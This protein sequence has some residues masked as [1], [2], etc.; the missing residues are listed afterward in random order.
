MLVFFFLFKKP[1]SSSVLKFSDHNTFASLGKKKK[2]KTNLGAQLVGFMTTYKGLPTTYNKDL[3]E[4]KEPLFD[5]HETLRACLTIAT[6]VLKTLMVFFCIWCCLV[7]VF[8]CF[9]FFLSFPRMRRVCGWGFFLIG[10]DPPARMRSALS[11]DM[12][13]TDLADFL[14]RKGVRFFPSSFHGSFSRARKS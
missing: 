12:L 11:E 13:A 6:G 7:W 9:F 1:P 4:D 5:A 8:F 10:K 3:Q 2:H 14:V